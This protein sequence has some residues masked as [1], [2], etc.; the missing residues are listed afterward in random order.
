MR[1]LEIL[2]NLGY[3]VRILQ[4]DDPNVKDPD[5]YV[6]KNGSGRL[7]LCAD[8]AISLV[9]FKV[10]MLKQSMTTDTTSDKIKFLNEEE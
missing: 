1:G 4:L 2:Q 10:K 7:N 6:L 8:K 9:E 5:E 3:D